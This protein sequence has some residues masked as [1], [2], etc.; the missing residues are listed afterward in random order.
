MSMGF[1]RP[2]MKGL[3]FSFVLFLI[4]LEIGLRITGRFS[5][6][7]ETIGSGYVSYYGKTIDSWY[8]TWSAD[9]EIV[10]DQPEFQITYMANSLGLR[11]KEVS[12]Q[13]PDSVFRIIC[14]GDSFTEGDGAEY[15]DSYPRFL[16]RKL[17]SLDDP[18][19]RYEVLNAG[20]CG[21]DLFYMNALVRDKLLRYRP[22]AIIYLINV[23]DVS[24]VIFRG[25]QERFLPDGTTRFRPAPWFEDAFRYSHA[26]R[27]V[28]RY[29]F[30]I[31]DSV[32]LT[33]TQLETAQLD[34]IEQ[35]S[36][37]IIIA[38]KMCN[39]ND[40]KCSVMV[41]AIPTESFAEL[42]QTLPSMVMGNNGPDRAME[43]MQEYMPLEHALIAEAGLNNGLT[44][45]VSAYSGMEREDY[46]WPINGH[47][48][49]EGY[50][51]FA[52]LVYDEVLRS[53]STFFNTY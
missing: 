11:E 53:D 39:E 3:A 25:G 6:Y 4:L 7:S 22:D 26:I 40:V 45:G 42:S 10:Y 17:N 23:S 15:S 41:H 49:A 18:T 48:N 14:A 44:I 51:I 36:E 35:L 16:E 21:S 9:T 5:T 28:C 1:Q 8:H 24:D 38:Q 12:A 32:L 34:A 13:K 30:D 50:R 43:L 27:M 20:I 37:E 19:M 31:D 2:N 33:R 47:F 46:A 52:D 29:V